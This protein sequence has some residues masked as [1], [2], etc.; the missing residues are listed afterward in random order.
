MLMEHD[1]RQL[2]GNSLPTAGTDGGIIPVSLQD[3]TNILWKLQ[4]E[5][6]QEGTEERHLSPEGKMFGKES[7]ESEVP[8]WG[9]EDLSGSAQSPQFMP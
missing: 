8:C 4:K 1:I 7:K 5:E 9:Q 2:G 6:T 3:W